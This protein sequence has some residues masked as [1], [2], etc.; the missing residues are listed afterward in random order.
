MSDSPVPSLFSRLLLVWL[1]GLSAVAYFW[2]FVDADPFTATKPLLN[3]MIAVTMFCLG[4]LLPA[5][6]VR[7]LMR[8]L[9]YVCFGTLV[10]CVVMPLAALVVVKIWGL[11]GGYRIGVIL[12]GCVPGAMASNV[13]TLAAQGNV[14]YSVS[15]TTLATLLSPLTVP[16][17]LVFMSGLSG[18]DIPMDPVLMMRT[19]CITVV[20]PVL[21]GYGLSR[22]SKRFEMAAQWA[23]PGIANIV[24]LWIIAVVVAISRDRLGQISIGV[25]L[26]LIVINVS[27]YV[28]G[29]FSG[30]I[31]RMPEAMRRALT[32]EVGMQNAGLGTVLA[33]A[34]FG[35]QY[36]EAA[37]PTAVYT[38]GCMLTGT[39]LVTIWRELGGLHASD[40]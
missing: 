40:E 1:V 9:P 13:L 15:L 4:S 22:L 31:I 18:T 33:V 28:G 23:G 36:P 6:E 5:D 35:K 29:Y 37:I 10:Q 39:A 26:G 34:T 12:V 3:A 20:V 2:P 8:Q 14:S 16:W 38:F 30:A 25:L 27:G 7:N 24:I 32:L 17:L 11:E 19:L 21:A